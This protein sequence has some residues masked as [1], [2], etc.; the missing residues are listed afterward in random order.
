[1]GS[2]LQ[3]AARGPDMRSLAR[4]MSDAFEVVDRV[5]RLMSFHTEQSE[6]SYL[7]RE[8]SRQPCEVHPWTYGVLRRALL[9]ADVS[10][11]LFDVCVAPALIEAGEL[12]RRGASES[13]IGNW[14]DIR[15]MRAY[16]VEYLQP[17]L[18]DLGGIAKGYAVD[19]AI[20]TLS[21][22]G[23]SAATVNAGGDLRRFGGDSEP[24]YLR[25]GD[26][27][28]PIA[29]LRHGAVAGSTSPASRRG[30]LAGAIGCIVD[31]RS[32]RPWDG[33]GEVCVAAPTCV[34]ADALT[35]VAA[36]A[37]PACRPLLARFGAQ[38]LW[39]PVP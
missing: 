13:H 7:N 22:G 10:G 28:L 1:M 11:G 16:R 14:R 15:L 5:E 2:L 33:N 6:L 36:L 38:A 3:I 37:G 39:C 32:G 8:A 35:K 27:L 4:A 30:R 25:A 12:P 34:A 9:F 31:P 24:V 19:R 17:I 23:C 18:I 21:R 26:G 20:H 29:Q